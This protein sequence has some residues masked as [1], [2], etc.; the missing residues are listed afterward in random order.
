MSPSLKLLPLT[1]IP[2]LAISSAQSPL[3][4]ARRR[5]T[6]SR[7]RVA[8]ETTVAS[9]VGTRVRAGVGRK[10]AV[11]A[12]PN[13]A[14]LPVV[15]NVEGALGVCSSLPASLDSRSGRADVEISLGS[16]WLLVS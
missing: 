5:N 12:T 13:A 3:G 15:G 7:A 2:I 16:N 8:L 1:I 4:D 11:A 10:V 14:R 9:T 6:C